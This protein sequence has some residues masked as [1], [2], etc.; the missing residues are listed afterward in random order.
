MRKNKIAGVI[1]THENL[2]S[3]PSRSEEMALEKKNYINE[4]ETTISDDINS[5]QLQHLNWKQKWQLR[6][7][8]LFSPAI[9]SKNETSAEEQKFVRKLDMV[10]MTYGCMAYC[11]KS[12]DQ[13]N[14]LNAYVSGM[15]EDVSET[16][17]LYENH[18]NFFSS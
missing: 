10:L 2:L 8:K 7:Q 11:I 17:P 3:S 4:V 13:S 15:K 16:I 18:A 14:Y 9:S 5:D 6:F 12:I 1:L